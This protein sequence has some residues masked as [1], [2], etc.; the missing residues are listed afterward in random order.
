MENE[1]KYIFLRAACLM[2][3]STIFYCTAFFK[4]IHARSH[5][6]IDVEA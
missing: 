1:L 3:L 2:D 5:S 4:N 6:E